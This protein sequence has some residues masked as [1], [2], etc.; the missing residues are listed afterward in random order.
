MFVLPPT[1]NNIFPECHS[2]Q[3]Q[4]KCGDSGRTRTCDEIINS[5]PFYQLNYR[6]INR[7]HRTGFEPVKN[8]IM[9]RVL[10]PQ[11]NGF[12]VGKSP[13]DLNR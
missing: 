4:H 1:M 13:P 8:P 3:G 7:E 10:F 9:G 6:V 12:I 11:A 2:G 5:H